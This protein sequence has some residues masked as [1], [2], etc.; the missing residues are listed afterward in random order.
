MKRLEIHVAG[1]SLDNLATIK[2]ASV[3][4]KAS[5]T[6]QGIGE[7]N[8]GFDMTNKSAKESAGAVLK[9]LMELIK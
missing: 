8:M 5:Y 1:L 4:G 9:K 6:E 7:I 2:K 3:T